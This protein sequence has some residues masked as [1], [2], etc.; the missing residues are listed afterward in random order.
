MMPACFALF[1]LLAVVNDLWFAV[2]LVV[3]ISL[4]YQATRHERMSEILGGALRFGGWIA[5]FMG[6]AFA[7][8]Y[9]LSIGL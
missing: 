7:V 2:P 3:A 5:V 1:P 8:I 9:Y 6:I 4:V